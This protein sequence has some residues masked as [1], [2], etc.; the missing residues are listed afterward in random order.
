[1]ESLHK[2]IPKEALPPELGG[3]YPLD[4]KALAGIVS[5]DYPRLIFMSAIQALLALSFYSESSV[6]VSYRLLGVFA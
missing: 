1:M 4:Y 5:E 6:D 3:T 2:Q